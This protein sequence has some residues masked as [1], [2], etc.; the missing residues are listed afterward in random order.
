[1][2]S[3]TTN[4]SPM[5]PS[6]SDH[7]PMDSRQIRNSVSLFEFKHGMRVSHATLTKLLPDA[8]T[9]LF[10]AKAYGM[11]YRRLSDL[12]RIVCPSDTVTA[13][14]KEGASHSSDLQDYIVDVAPGVI[15]PQSITM[16]PDE[17]FEP[18][19]TELLGE[20]VEQA[21]VQVAQSITDVA[22]KLALVLESLP[23]K[24]GEMTFQHLERLN[25]QR[26]AIGTFDAQIVHKPVPPRLVVLDVSG[27]M[28]EDTIRRIVDE[29]VGMAYQ[30]DASLAIVSDNAFF[31]DA[32]TFDTNDVLDAAEYNGT[33]YEQLAD[34]FNRDWETVITVADYDSSVAAASY[35]RA[36]CTGRIGT[37]LDISLV[38][39]PT[40]LAQCIAPL[41]QELKPVLLGNSPYVPSY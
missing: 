18:P 39:Q 26:N 27:S 16:D 25:R 35:I 30:V 22:N 33:H 20:L 9:A 38:N 6:P 21:A 24:Y 8:K 17:E 13:L 12:L 32:G 1:M 7:T 19:D 28:S 15:D 29:V 4:S 10:F 11:D 41:A 36:N 3:T 37:I 5:S 23:S 34:I 14:L 40:Y 31:W 2:T